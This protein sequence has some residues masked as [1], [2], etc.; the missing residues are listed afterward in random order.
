[1]AKTEWLVSLYF[2]DCC[3]DGET[4]D[5]REQVIQAFRK[6]SGSLAVKLPSDV[7]GELRLLDYN[8]VEEYLP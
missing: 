1:M 3:E 5:T 7:G 8:D 2:E 6:A 4:P